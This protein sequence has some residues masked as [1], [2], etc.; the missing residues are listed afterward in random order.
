MCPSE[1][2]ATAV[3][4]PP[5]GVS[6]CFYLAKVKLIGPPQMFLFFSMLLIMDS[7]KSESELEFALEFYSNLKKTR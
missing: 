5:F 6:H 1:N 7:G 2:F 4:L 3:T